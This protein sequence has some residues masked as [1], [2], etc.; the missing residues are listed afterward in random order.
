[1]DTEYATTG[2]I[3]QIDQPRVPFAPD[4]TLFDA[5]YGGM[6]GGLVS[7]RDGTPLGVLVTQNGLADLDGDGVSDDSFDFVALSQIWEAFT[8]ADLVA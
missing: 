7:A 8:N 3:G 6:S 5:V 1:M 2:W 4:S